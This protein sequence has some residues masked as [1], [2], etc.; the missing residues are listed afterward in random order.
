[1]F[2]DPRNIYPMCYRHHFTFWHKDVTE[3]AKWF[4]LTY[5]LDYLYLEDAKKRSYDF[6]NPVTL[7]TLFAAAEQGYEAYQIAYDSLSPAC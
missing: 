6:N 5:P 4:E 3:W 2:I 7:E 1:M